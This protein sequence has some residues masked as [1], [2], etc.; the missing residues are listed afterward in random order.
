VRLLANFSP[1]LLL[2]IK[3]QRDIKGVTPMK[4]FLDTAHVASIQKLA[5]TG[6]IAGVTTNP[7]HLSNEDGSPLDV[8]KKICALLPHGA[9]SVE[10]TEQKPEEVY[11][12]AQKIAKIAPNVVV[13]IPCHLDYCELIHK[14]VQEGVKI[15][16]TL[17]F[18]VLQGLMMAQLG[19]AYISPFVGRLDDND[20]NGIQLVE[21][22]RFVLDQYNLPTQLLAASLRSVRQVHE[23]AMAGADVA[24]M[25]PEIF[26]QL[27]HH[28][29]TDD[30]ME[31]FESDWKKLE[32]KQFP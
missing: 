5:A 4:I 24:T 6:L 25:K 31:L 26:E 30:G 14:L 12:Q 20:V 10:V 21:D 27:L 13:K 7:T 1:F 16:I 32:I 11:R 2:F 17:V 22:L 19:V 8:V 18:T 29:L 28:P 15:N 23:V 9:I 3:P